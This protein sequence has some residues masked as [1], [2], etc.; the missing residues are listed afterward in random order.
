MSK[1]SMKLVAA[2]ITAASSVWMTPALAGD[3]DVVTESRDSG[4][5]FGTDYTVNPQHLSGPYAFARSPRVRANE[6]PF[7]Q[8]DFQLQGRD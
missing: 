6:S 1:T 5:Y 4:R 3:Q 8:R 2:L 7:P